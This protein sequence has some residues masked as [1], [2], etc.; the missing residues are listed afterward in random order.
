MCA[1]HPLG[2]L[3]EYAIGQLFGSGA[4]AG[5]FGTGARQ[6]DRDVGDDL[7]RAR[8]QDDDPVRKDHRLSNRMRDEQRRRAARLPQAWQVLRELGPGEFVHGAEGF[9]QQQQAGP[10]DQ[11]PGD[12]GALAHAPGQFGRAGAV[13]ALQSD[14]GDQLVDLPGIGRLPRQVQR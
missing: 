6:V 10:R 3:S 1:R 4:A 13:E 9:V 8:R 5:V 7:G 12:G 11:R 14:E 2:Q